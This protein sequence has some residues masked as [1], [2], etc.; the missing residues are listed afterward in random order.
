MSEKHLRK[1][2]LKLIN[3]SDKPK[4]IITCPVCGGVSFVEIK[5]TMHRT[6]TGASQGVKGKACLMC[7]INGIAVII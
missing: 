4:E 3:G 7:L 2:E 6:K 5:H 1:P